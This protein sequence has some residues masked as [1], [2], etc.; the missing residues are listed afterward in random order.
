MASEDVESR[1]G[2]VAWMPVSR[3]GVAGLSEGTS[4]RVSPV[5]QSMILRSQPMVS[6]RRLSLRERR[7]R[8][9][10]MS[11]LSRSERRQ[12]S[13]PQKL[14]PALHRCLGGAADGGVAQRLQMPARAATQLILEMVRAVALAAQHA[15]VGVEQHGVVLA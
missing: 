9:S 1:R 15:A 3:G 12:S 5:N 8:H 4:R 6:Q 11:A 10:R 13:I 7:L 2:A 14:K